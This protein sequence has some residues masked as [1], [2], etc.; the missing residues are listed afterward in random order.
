MGWHLSLFLSSA[1]LGAAG[2]SSRDWEELLYEAIWDGRCKR[3]YE[4]PAKSR[5]NFCHCRLSC[6]CLESP[7]PTLTLPGPQASM[8]GKKEDGWG[9]LAPQGS[10]ALRS[11]GMVMVPGSRAVSGRDGLWSP[12]APGGLGS[13]WASGSSLCPAAATGV[14]SMKC[15]LAVLPLRR[16]PW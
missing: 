9:V 13:A 15:L 11:Q 16:V 8:P 5:E 4:V 2:E 10:P 7:R 6:R 14:S 1:W 3:S 12:L